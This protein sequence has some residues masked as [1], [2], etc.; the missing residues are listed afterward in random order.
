VTLISS[1]SKKEESIQRTKVRQELPKYPRGILELPLTVSPPTPGQTLELVGTLKCPRKPK[2]PGQFNQQE[3]LHSLGRH[4]ILKADPNN[5]HITIQ[6]E[7]YLGF[8]WKLL[9]HI[10]SKIKSILE[11]N[12]DAHTFPFVYAILLGDKQELSHQTKDTFLRTGMYHLLAISGL[13]IGIFSL[14]LLTFFSLLRI[15]R[16]CRFILVFITLWLYA[17]LTGFP[18]SVVRATFMFSFFLP[19]ILWEKSNYAL[20]SLILTAST[21]LLLAPYQIL[22]LGFQLSVLATF[23]LLYYNSFL[24]EK[25]DLLVHLLYG[26]FQKNSVSP[27]H[28]ISIGFTRLLSFTVHSMLLSSLLLFITSPLL[29]PINQTSTPISVLGNLVAGVL[30]PLILSSSLFVLISASFGIPG[31]HLATAFGKATSTLTYGL[32]NSLEWLMSLPFSHFYTPEISSF[33][34]GS[35]WIFFILLPITFKTKKLLPFILCFFLLYSGWYA[36]KWI[37]NYFF[38]PV[39][40]V[41]LDVDQGDGTLIRLPGNTHILVDG[42]KG[43]THTGQGKYTILPYLGYSRIPKLSKIIVTHADW[44]HYGGLEYVTQRV[45]VDTFVYGRMQS[46]SKSWNRLLTLIDQKEI[47]I[48]HPS[49]GDTLFHKK[50]PTSITL[51]VLSPC[52]PKQFSSKNENSLVLKLQVGEQC[53]LLTGDIED[54]AESWLS[55]QSNIRCDLLKAPHHGSKTSSHSFFL[56]AVQPKIAVVSAG[57]HNR[58]KHPHPTVLERY[59]KRNVAMYSTAKS[60]AISC[61]FHQEGIACEEYVPAFN[62]K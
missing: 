39:S 42:G 45:P 13:H 2:N 54:Q 20:Y 55:T 61:I 48:I 21:M 14:F 44:D 50:T 53:A 49:C 22:S 40:I 27:E 33:W 24:K 18:V 10:R 51:T 17:A 47:P 25:C 29:F 59:R 43:N 3:Y 38:T 5:S 1:S 34:C 12:L 30:M 28:L 6:K 4:W 60:G 36:T 57:E 7:S 62:Q 52:F 58:Y 23:F 15:P 8:L 35:I 9:Q 56:E 16:K 19:A 41:F 32:E 37:H 11:K 26:W 46:T 31:T